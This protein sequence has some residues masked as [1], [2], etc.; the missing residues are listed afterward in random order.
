MRE[1]TLTLADI[2]VACRLLCAETAACFDRFGQTPER[3]PLA[4]VGMQP[5]EL[6][7]ARMYYPPG[8][9]DARLEFSELPARFSDALIPH[10]RCVFHGTA[11]LFDD[12]AYIFTAPSGTGKTTQYV[13][14]KL[15]LGKRI[16]M[17]NGDKPILEDRNGVF[18]VRPSPWAG[19]ERM[20]TGQ[21]APL[22][23]LILLEQ[24][25]EDRVERLTVQ[26]A[27]VPIFSQFL[28]TA[29]TEELV[30]QTAA[31]AGRLLQQT[32]V[33]KLTN[34]GDEASAWLGSREI[35]GIE[36]EMG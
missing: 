33:W 13:L 27:A 3:T 24:G 9:E 4:W 25:R 23:G 10:G 30:Q 32:P 2:P 5:E 20:S 8:F 31:L 29:G 16:Q 1:I 21:S 28:F 17:L 6:E 18:W 14:W 34:R 35:L 36:E 11:F 26:Q 7:A 15:L 22:G 19:K 12:K